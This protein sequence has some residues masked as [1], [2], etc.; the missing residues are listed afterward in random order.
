MIYTNLDKLRE[1]NKKEEYEKSKQDEDK[2]KQEADSAMKLLKDSQMFESILMQKEEEIN[3]VA[4]DLS[5][6]VMARAQGGFDRSIVV[7]TKPQ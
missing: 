5:K 2:K 6:A 1:I 3:K 4:K 7:E